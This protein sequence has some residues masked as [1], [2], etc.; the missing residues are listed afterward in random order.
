VW[1]CDNQ[2]VP[3]STL[4]WPSY[5]AVCLQ[6]GCFHSFS[7]VNWVLTNDLDPVSIRIEC[8]SDAT[9]SSVRQLLLEFVTGIF[10]S[11]ASSLNVVDTDTSMPETLYRFTVSS[12]DFIIGVVLGSVV[13][14]QLDQTF[15]IA[16]VVVVGGR[17]W[18]VIAQKVE[19]ELGFRLF[20]LSNHLHTE[21]LIE[22][23]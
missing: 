15:A 10:D 20:D 2:Y 23:D 8:K 3:R 14:C 7:L 1:F 11:L 18:R 5:H 9:H 22:L 16:E 21:V 19:V 17:F 4:L 12:C 6:V 13:M